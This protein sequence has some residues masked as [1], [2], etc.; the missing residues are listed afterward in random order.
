M[1]I[2]RFAGAGG[3]VGLGAL[4][5][6]ERRREPS[7]ELRTRSLA[8]SLWK[9]HD[10]QK[11]CSSQ[12]MDLA[13]VCMGWGSCSWINLGDANSP[14]ALRCVVA[15]SGKV[16]LREA[17]DG[18]SGQP[19]LSDGVCLSL[20]IQ[21][22]GLWWET[23]SV[24]VLWRRGAFREMEPVRRAGETC[25]FSCI[26]PTEAAQLGWLS[27]DL[28]W[29]LSASQFL[30]CQ[31]EQSPVLPSVLLG[32]RGRMWRDVGP[33]GHV[34]AGEEQTLWHSGRF[35]KGWE[36]TGLSEALGNGCK[37]GDVCPWTSLPEFRLGDHWITAARRASR[38][39]LPPP[40]FHWILIHLISPSYP[41]LHL[42][43]S[44]N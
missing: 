41:N 26:E 7:W 14:D 40:A 27:L 11:L 4:R 5:M 19:R 1:D 2:N 20:Q 16:L 39:P 23:G 29:L 18:A 33:P 6:L 42:L 13:G 43:S 31:G 10:S 35:A 24:A 25:A 44:N 12:V 9:I 32:E 22:G 36:L 3:G 30:S 38:R 17:G 8:N 37:A 34:H 21:C 15:G 28:G